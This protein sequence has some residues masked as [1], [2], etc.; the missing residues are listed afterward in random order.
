MLWTLY[1]LTAP[2]AATF[3]WGSSAERAIWLLRSLSC[4]RICAM[5]RCGFCLRASC[6]ACF[7]VSCSGAGGAAGGCCAKEASGS[8]SWRIAISRTIICRKVAAIYKPPNRQTESR[9]EFYPELPRGWSGEKKLI[10]K[11]PDRETKLEDSR[12]YSSRKAAAR[13]PRQAHFAQE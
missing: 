9:A 11:A 12:G 1:W 3:A 6:T 4:T 5:S 2:D 10:L 13:Q 7:S 8:D